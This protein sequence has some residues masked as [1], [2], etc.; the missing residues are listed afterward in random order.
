MK[1]S[2]WRRGQRLRLLALEDRTVPAGMPHLVVD[3]N[4]VTPDSNPEQIVAVGPTAY[5]AANDGI[6]GT[7]LWKSDG[8]D[9]GTV[10][11]RTSIWV[12][13]S[14]SECPFW[15]ALGPTT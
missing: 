5:F 4:T 11:S 7:E 10:W 1:G 8:A 13:T 6:H 3:I 14:N 9:A 15:P 2:F 12:R